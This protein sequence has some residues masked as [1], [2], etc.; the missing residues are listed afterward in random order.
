MTTIKTLALILAGTVLV[1]GQLCR[2]G[3]GTVTGDT[4]YKY[5]RSESVS[6]VS[7]PRN[8]Q[9]QTVTTTTSRRS[10]PRW[11]RVGSHWYY[12]RSQLPWQPNAPG[13]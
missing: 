6:E 10:A 4:E 3:D 9:V 8:T 2:A 13:G 12:L 11:V 7:A 1:P 5:R